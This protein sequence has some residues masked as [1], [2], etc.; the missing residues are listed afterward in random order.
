MIITSIR[1]DVPPPRTKVNSSFISKH[2]S[3]AT[4]NA[5]W[6]VPEAMRLL[7]SA[8]LSLAI[9]QEEHHGT[10]TVRSTRE[11][12]LFT[13]WMEELVSIALITSEQAKRVVSSLSLILNSI[14]NS[15]M[16]C[17]CTSSRW[18]LSRKYLGIK[19]SQRRKVPYVHIWGTASLRKYIMLISDAFIH[20][21]PR[22]E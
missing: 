20:V 13:F 16:K 9:L 14:R 15:L 19:R 18:R 10:N 21:L 12:R 6:G 17:F 22:G 11:H 4:I 1:D 8:H 3:L 5:L 2:M 7:T